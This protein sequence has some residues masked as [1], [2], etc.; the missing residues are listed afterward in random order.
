MISGDVSPEEVRFLSVTAERW[1]DFESLFGECGAYE[2]AGA[3][4][5]A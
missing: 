1:A 3:C 4:G 2:A 5:G